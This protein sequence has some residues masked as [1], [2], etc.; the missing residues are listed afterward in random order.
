MTEQPQPPSLGAVWPPPPGQPV[1]ALPT[2]AYASWIRRVGAF[3]I[4]QIVYLTLVVILGLGGGLIVGAAGGSSRLEGIVRSILILVVLAFLIWNWGYRQGRT[5]SSIGKSVLK[6]KVVSESTGEPI[7]FGLSIV[8]Y[9][10]HFVDYII[11]NIG[12]LLP[13]FTA[14]RQTIADM[15]MGT[16]CLPNEAPSARRSRTP[17]PR[18]RMALGVGVLAIAA[19]LTV[20]AYLATRSHWVCT[21][22]GSWPDCGPQGED[23]WNYQKWV[24]PIGYGAYGFSEP[25]TQTFL[26]T[27][28][29]TA[30][31]LILRRYNGWTYGLVPI[32]AIVAFAI[33]SHGRYDWGWYNNY[34]AFLACVFVPT[35]VCVLIARGITRSVAARHD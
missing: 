29:W 17:R 31:I 28:L 15:I 30:G 14:K 22:G 4:D 13:L 10:A 16:V 26:A 32:A 7:G 1:D 11:C 21:T 25:H 9:F 18:I 19:V 20:L 24:G 6:F 8:R 33:F 23:D 12:Y 27:A 5:G 2:E 3:L 35:A 34:F